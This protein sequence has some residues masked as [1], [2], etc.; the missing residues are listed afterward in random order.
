[1]NIEGSKRIWELDFLKGIIIIIMVWFHIVFDLKEYYNYN[2]S[3]T[4]GLLFYVSRVA[5]ILFMLLPGI[6]CSISNNNLRRGVKLIAIAIFLTVATTL[7][8]PDYS[9]KFG[10][11]HLIGSSIILYEVIKK[12]KTYLILFL[13]VAII[14]LGNIVSSMSTT[15]NYFFPLGIMNKDFYSADYYPLIPW[16]GIFLIGIVIG[17]VFYS[18]KQ[19]YM[20]L[21]YHNSLIN[22]I[23]RRSL[24]IYLVHQP[25]ILLILYIYHGIK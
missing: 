11:L 10:I 17:R 15:S 20:K 22:R 4:S 3:Y 14:W 9:I 6:N 2:V 16:F 8:G 1:M 23:G 21:N 19:G 18:N 5:V 13:S 12:L 25:I 7:A 24:I